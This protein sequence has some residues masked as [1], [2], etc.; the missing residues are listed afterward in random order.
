VAG[1]A[2][3]TQSAFSS[4]TP[5]YGAPEQWVPK[6]YGQT[7]PWT[8][9]WGLALTMVE[10]MAGRTVIDGDQ[11][12]MMG[13]VLDPKRRPTPQNEG[14]DVSDAVEAVFRR[15]LAVD[16]RD[17]YP[18]AGAFWADL[19]QTLGMRGEGSDIL[20]PRD[21]RAE[22]G[23]VPRLETVEAAQQGVR[24]RIASGAHARMGNAV[25]AQAAVAAGVYPEPLAPLA[26]PGPPPLVPDLNIPDLGVPA[27]AP[28]TKSD[29][30]P[31]YSRELD[32]DDTPSATGASS[33]EVDLDL[34][35]GERPSLRQPTSRPDWPI[36]EAPAAPP[37]T[38]PRPRV[39][40]GANPM[41]HANPPPPS[42]NATAS[43]AWPAQHTSNPPLS[44]RVASVR[45]LSEASSTLSRAAISS[46]PPPPPPLAFEEPPSLVRRLAPGALLVLFSIVITI[47]D[48]MYAAS[49]GEVFTL[50]PLRSGW[51]SGGFMVV[52]VIL[53]AIRLIPAQRP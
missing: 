22:V 35:P 10:I 42:Q 48:Q 13:T 20:P 1:R 25:P 15:A 4:F 46:R 41:V 5:A 32:F 52:G 16:P 38:E 17:R 31:R 7:G 8:D 53:I 2:S 29:A 34:E 9:V 26:Q 21:Q 23:M 51:L 36:P 12:G 40:S 47:A 43:G 44:T 18:D 49:T 14:L 28:K 11:A 30:A 33:L 50:G 24:R 45:P 27:G 3:Q 39:A 37:A 6:R 19:V